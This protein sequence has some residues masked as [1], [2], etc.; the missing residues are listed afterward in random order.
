M[1]MF[2]R[3]V[4]AGS[5][6]KAASLVSVSTPQMSRAITELETRLHTRL[7]HRTTRHMA[8]VDLAKAGVAPDFFQTDCFR[9]SKTQFHISP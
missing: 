6:T 1:R 2:V 3:V 5:F 4:E 9:P 8:Q 7:L